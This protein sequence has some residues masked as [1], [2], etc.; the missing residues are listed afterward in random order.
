M[1][2]SLKSCPRRPELGGVETGQGCFG[3]GFRGRGSS[4]FCSVGFMKVDAVWFRVYRGFGG[5]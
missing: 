2:T 1:P 5:L 4:F 3:V